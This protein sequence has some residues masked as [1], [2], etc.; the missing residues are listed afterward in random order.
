MFLEINCILFSIEDRKVDNMLGVNRDTLSIQVYNAM[1]QRIITGEYSP[2]TKLTEQWVAKELS[3]SPT[4]VREAFRRLTAE[5][6]LENAPY[7]GVIVKEYSYRDIKEAYL[8]RAKLMLLVIELI[9]QKC[10]DEEL[11][12]L[13]KLLDEVIRSDEKNI[14]FKFYPFYVKIYNM[15]S[16]P[17]VLAATLTLNAIINID[18]LRKV[19]FTKP[20]EDEILD[21]QKLMKYI[22]N[23]EVKEAQ[24]LIEK[25]SNELMD[26]VLSDYNNK[27]KMIV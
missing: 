9:I 22:K 4:P 20:L 21:H 18:I 26:M 10:S 17:I 8:V 7:K 2:S 24:G 5:G 6:F 23:R 16:S 27:H 25:L 15:A 11:I 12:S 19:N 3:V 13:E 1:K 14:A